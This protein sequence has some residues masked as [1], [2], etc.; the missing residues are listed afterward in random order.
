MNKTQIKI[1]EAAESELAELGFAGASIRH[2]TRRAGVNLA[3]INYHFGSKEELIKALFKY[4]INPLNQL[5][6]QLLKDEQA[7]VEGG[8]VPVS[9]LVDILVRP[10]VENMLTPEGS[11]FVQAMAR[12]MSEPLGFMEQL[13]QEIFQEIFTAF[14]GALRKAM[15]E[16]DGASVMNQMN[17]TVCSMVGIMIH[18]PRMDRFHGHQLSKAEFNRVLDQF[19]RFIS[20]GIQGAHDL[21]ST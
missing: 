12:C 14:Y 3:S 6:L 7:K 2:I 21:I 11:K 9:V 13:D 5:R 17:F 19:I 20:S 4:R 15:P 10:T 1:L 8:V 16:L 18:F